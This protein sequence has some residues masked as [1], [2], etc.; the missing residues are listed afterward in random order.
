MVVSIIV[1][2]LLMGAS[3]VILSTQFRRSA[4]VLSHVRERRDDARSLVSRA[5]YDLLREPSLGNASS[6][7]RG[8]SIL[9]DMYGY[10]WTKKAI[11]R[12]DLTPLGNGQMFQLS[13]AGLVEILQTSTTSP[14]VV[15]V[16]DFAGFVVTITRYYS[17]S[18][19]PAIIIPVSG[20]IARYDVDTGNAV[21]VFSKDDAAI[22]ESTSIAPLLNGTFDIVVNNR[23]FGGTGAG[24]FY[25]QTPID[26]PALSVSALWPNRVGDSK[27]VLI[28]GY[29]FRN[30]LPTSGPNRLSTNEDYD[31]VDYQNM[32]LSGVMTDDTGALTEPII[33]SFYREN[34]SGPSF[35]VNST[36]TPVVDN[37]GDGVNDSI[38]M[39]L[40][41]P[42][43][44]DTKGRV[45]KPLV[46]FHVVDLDGRLNLNAHGNLIDVPPGMFKTDYTAFWNGPPTPPFPLGQ[47]Y[48]P[49]EVDLS[50]V[51]GGDYSGLL[52]GN[53]TFL[54]RYGMDQL[55]G[56][57]ARD[58]S[59]ALKLFGYPQ[60]SWAARG[61]VGN[62]FG[63]PMD[64]H[65][66]LGYGHPWTLDYATSTIPVGMPVADIASSSLTDE[67]VNSPYEM[68]FSKASFSP[69]PNGQDTPFSAKELE[70][71]LRMND[72]D[73]LM[74]SSRLLTP[75]GPGLQGLLNNS[76]YGSTPGLR[77]LITTDSF[78]VP[79]PP[80]SLVEK[81][82]KAL[83][84]AI[85]P[86]PTSAQIAAWIKVMLGPELTRGR[87]L[88]I[89][90]AFGNGI[91]DN[92]NGIVD[93]P[94]EAITGENFPD[95][96]GRTFGMDSNGDGVI[97]G[98]S[99][100]LGRY[101]FAKNLYVTMLLVT[102]CVDRNGNGIFGTVAIGSPD[103]INDWYDFNG[104]NSVDIDDV[105]DYRRLVA[106]WAVNVVDYRDP[107]A[108]MTP[109]EFDLNPW[110]GWGV[111][112]ALVN[113]DLPSPDNVDTQPADLAI[114]WGAERPE[115]LITESSVNHQRSTEDESN[116]NGDMS[117]IVANGGTD[118]DLDSNLLPTASAFFELYAP[119]VH[120]TNPA[121]NGNNEVYPA[122][123]YGANGVNLQRRSIDG[124]SP[125]WRLS[126]RRRYLGDAKPDEPIPTNR[127]TRQVYFVEP[128]LP[129]LLGP[130]VYYPDG[131][132]VP[133]LVPG[134]YAVVGSMGKT[135]G[136][137][138]TT[139]F[140][141]RTTSTWDTELDQTRQI[142]LL[143][144]SS[145][146]EM[147]TWDGVDW[148]PP[149]LRNAVAIPVSQPDSSFPNNLRSFGVTD[150]LVGYN[151]GLPANVVVQSVA[152][153]WQYFD[154]TTALPYVFDTPRDLS[155][156]SMYPTPSPSINEWT[157]I[158]YD[159]VVP[160]PNGLD[161]PSY[162]DG[163]LREDGL[164]RQYGAV[165][166]QRLANPLEPFNVVTNPY[167]TV[168]G[169]GIDVNVFNGV[170]SED[171][172]DA[173]AVLPDKFANVERGTNDIS[174]NRSRWFWKSILDGRYNANA[175]T[176]TALLPSDS[177]Y[178]SHE[179]FN[180]FGQVDQVYSIAGN[181]AFP[182]LK[183]NNR[184]FVSQLELAEIPYSSS[185]Q[186]LSY[187]DTLD[188]PTNPRNPFQGQRVI[189][190]TRTDNYIP[191]YAGQFG[192][193]F[194][195]HTDSYS[196]PSN[197]SPP[198]R[199]LLH[200]TRY[201]TIW[202]FHRG[203][204]GQKCL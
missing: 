197:Q 29:L 184:P 57:V 53:G 69:A 137:R 60:R 113:S 121:I 98:N 63:S 198:L 196:R 65:G 85:D 194:G 10:G 50:G 125:V 89:N 27:D 138:Y 25:E 130:K 162:V 93:E 75:Q 117:R 5:F 192:H 145:R 84:D 122:E 9:G 112:G 100:A 66:R 101:H 55:P 114:V 14:T 159:Q 144:G 157:S 97:G 135:D 96:Y 160:V 152:D 149:I 45:Y 175:V 86:D 73:A 6:P 180:S 39:D 71:I 21:I 23:Q 151:V 17:P 172:V 20:R 22:V 104:V 200:F 143:P 47:G 64:I 40:N 43:Q 153:G 78:D 165:Y 28:N 187:F 177:H 148:D 38:W 146:V 80:S 173:A 131:I 119:W 179:L 161:I 155:Q 134:N 77:R 169:L 58:L 126:I 48:G 81:L 136:T 132:T 34:L 199:V 91:D 18:G 62:L 83:V 188:S 72:P 31:A 3:F 168:D 19:Q 124:T 150:P 54:G 44:T 133:E 67:I 30:T 33:P 123:L 13:L 105:L 195:F 109:F 170:S 51:L 174:L 37:D 163:G 76:V 11:P 147:R 88:D 176:T 61:L 108:I 110:N 26:Q 87:K 139:Y 42:I 68:D 203:L 103:L 181:D 186:I 141:R 92:G 7:L 171:E 16:A 158:Y 15:P 59:S 185:Y 41:Y 95:P 156:H 70:R 52:L 190:N 204:S 107:D 140:G 94:A 12:T 4:S 106:Q 178:Y 193:L 189:P 166:L 102:E 8:H 79:V 90:R 56:V 142:S 35:D 49:P 116:D 154:T 32:F 36:G 2:F 191:L 118:N 201:W 182:W 111:N 120:T 99:E 24:I 74:L 115:L 129:A 167:I 82:G 183:W 46:A 128:T 164:H 202:K 127:E 1:L